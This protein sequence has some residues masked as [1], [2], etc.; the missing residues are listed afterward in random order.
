MKLTLTTTEPVCIGSGTLLEHKLQT[1]NFLNL[2]YST[3][4][5]DEGGIYAWSYN[6]KVEVDYLEKMIYQ[7]DV[8]YLYIYKYIDAILLNNRY[9]RRDDS[10]EYKEAIKKICLR[11]WE[12]LVDVVTDRYSIKFDRKE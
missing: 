11:I 6:L 2:L 1:L 10:V 8:P 9:T 7:S 5:G 12:D 3:I 4:V